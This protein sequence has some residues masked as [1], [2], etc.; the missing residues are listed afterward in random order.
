MGTFWVVALRWVKRKSAQLVAS[1]QAE[2]AAAGERVDRGPEAA[3]Y[4]GASGNRSRVKGNGI[5][6]LTDRRV[7][8]R[9]LFGAAVDVPIADVT[10]V[11]DGKWFLRAYAGGRLHLILQLKGGDEVGFM[12]ADHPGW[13]AAIR[14]RLP[15]PALG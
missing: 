2:L 14:E 8:F 5:I 3:L 6:V 15:A 9:K 10:G 11:R 1:M 7:L 4:R 13:M 12:V